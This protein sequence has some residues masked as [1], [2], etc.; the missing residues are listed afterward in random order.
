MYNFGYILSNVILYSTPA[1]T[2][3]FNRSNAF[4]ENMVD[5]LFSI[6]Y[7]SANVRLINIHNLTPVMN[8]TIF[9][10]SESNGNTAIVSATSCCKYYI[11]WSMQPVNFTI[12]PLFTY[13]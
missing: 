10:R 11:V 5:S 12:S 6:T 7:S 8:S 4:L 3:V 2:S 13:E 1:I 9:G